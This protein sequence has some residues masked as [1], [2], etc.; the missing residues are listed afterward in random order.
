LAPDAIHAREGFVREHKKHTHFRDDIMDK[1]FEQEDNLALFHKRL[2]DFIKEN[3]ERKDGLLDLYRG[4]VAHI[5]TDELFMLTIRKEFSATMEEH[6]IAQSDRPYFDYII[7]DMNR[8]DLLL[9]NHYEGSE[10]IRNWMEQVPIYPVKD[11]LSEQEI[12]KSRD[13]LICR[14]FIEKHELIEPIYI[15]YDRILEFIQQA[16][17][18]IV[19]RLSEGGSLPTMF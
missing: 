16:A 15:S 2:A 18:S 17:V 5:I 13:W 19:E 3:R 1:D 14:H 9:V 7:S 11:Y 8:N 6:G 4:Y 10:E 12:S